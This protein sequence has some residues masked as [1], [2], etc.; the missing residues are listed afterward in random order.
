MFGGTN[1][2]AREKIRGW[3]H[4]AEGTFMVHALAILYARWF[5]PEE[6]GGRE[7]VLKGLE[8]S[9]GRNVGGDLDCEIFPYPFHPIFLP[10]IPTSP[11]QFKEIK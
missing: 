3:I 6:V 11:L 8:G 7:E 5:L 4:A 1:L 9:L 10:P 2:I